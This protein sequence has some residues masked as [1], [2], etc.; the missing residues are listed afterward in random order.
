[1]G[2]KCYQTLEETEDIRYVED[3]GP[4]KCTHP[5]SWLGVGYYLWDRRISFAH[6]WG[7]HAY[8]KFGKNYLIGEILLDVTF[9]CFDI[10]NDVDCQ[11][12]FEEILEMAKTHPKFIGK[13]N[14]V[15]KVI[16]VLK[17]SGRFDYHSIRTADYPNSSIRISF[18]DDVQKQEYTITNPRIQ[19]CVINSK[20]VFLSPFSVIYP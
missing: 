14:S 1:M 20:E 8:V 9:K 6:Q 7:N 5:K 13:K 10:H 3:N 12:A 2:V 4:F 19:I 15:P 16:E 18:S 11:M 17:A